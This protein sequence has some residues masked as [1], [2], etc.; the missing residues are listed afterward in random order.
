[1]QRFEIPNGF[2]ACGYGATAGPNGIEESTLLFAPET[3]EQENPWLD[4]DAISVAMTPATF[5]SLSKYLREQQG[6]V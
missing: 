3:G 6:G 4:P 1:M 5:A 2:I